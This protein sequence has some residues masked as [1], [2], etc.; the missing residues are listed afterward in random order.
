MFK[1]S[2]ELFVAG[3]FWFVFGFMVMAV[4]LAVISAFLAVQG[5][6]LESATYY[7]GRPTSRAFYESLVANGH[8]KTL[9]HCNI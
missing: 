1:K 5:R 9:V 4:P 2:S 8:Y 6:Y 3:V 7:H